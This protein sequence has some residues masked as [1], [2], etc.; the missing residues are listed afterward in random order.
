MSP[1]LSPLMPI[2]TIRTVGRINF[3]LTIVWNN[4]KQKTS[5]IGKKVKKK[6]QLKENAIVPT[7]LRACFPF[8][9]NKG[10][11][12]AA[13]IQWPKCNRSNWNKGTSSMTS[14]QQF[15]THG[16]TLSLGFQL[17]SFFPNSSLPKGCMSTSNER[18]HR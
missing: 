11:P 9:G 12:F 5:P 16:R 10:Y 3:T 13:N 4:T 2:V 7:I 17:T 18:R 6:N 1:I 14:K 8:I 15:E